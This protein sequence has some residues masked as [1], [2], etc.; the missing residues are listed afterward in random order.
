MDDA[1]ACPLPEMSK[2]VPWSGDV[3]M[4]GRPRVTLTPDPNETVLNAA[5]PT[6]WYGAT[7]PSNAPDSARVK[8]VSAGSGSET[9]M[10][11]NRA[12]AARTEGKCLTS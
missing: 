11:A 5:M 3:R 9:S 2:A 1:S 6:S 7:T 10:P 4:K 12:A 8:T